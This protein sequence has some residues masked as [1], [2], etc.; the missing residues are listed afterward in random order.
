MRILTLI[1]FIFFT[2]HLTC[3]QNEYSDTELDEMIKSYSFYISQLSTVN[4]VIEKYPSLK[5]EANT[6]QNLWN[7]KFKSSI[8]NIE[9]K[10]N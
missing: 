8:D 5:Y 1:F 4:G 10:L 7:L 3:A 9:N 2:C 6:A